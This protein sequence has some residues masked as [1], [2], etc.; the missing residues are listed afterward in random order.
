MVSDSEADQTA[1]A[2]AFDLLYFIANKRL[3]RSLLTVIDAINV[4][5]HARR[6]I[7]QCASLHGVDA[8]AIVLDPPFEYCVARNAG[9]T[10][11]HV[12]RD[13][14]RAQHV[15]LSEALNRST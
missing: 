12:G 11:R 10:D 8:F 7:M 15:L 2:D 3:S 5:P 1:T 13:A 14:I 9:R 6:Q 4:T